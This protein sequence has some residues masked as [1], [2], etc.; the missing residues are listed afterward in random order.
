MSFASLKRPRILFGG[1]AIAA[2]AAVVLALGPGNA[3]VAS[4][5][6]ASS[7]AKVTPVAATSPSANPNTCPFGC[8]TGNGDY[9]VPAPPQEPTLVPTI[10]TKTTQRIYGADPYQ[11]A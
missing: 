1:T 5:Q 8:P 3:G 10:G 9:K 4:T 6:A 11:Q 2:A 7:P